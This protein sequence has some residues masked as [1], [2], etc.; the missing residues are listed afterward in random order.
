MNRHSL[1]VSLFLVV[2]LLFV[3]PVGGP[4]AAQ[5][6]GSSAQRTLQTLNDVNIPIRRA[7]EL[8]ERLGG[9]LGAAQAPAHLA[10]VYTPGDRH[11]FFVGD[12]DTDTTFEVEAELAAA[13]PG[14]YL[15]VEDGVDYDPVLLQQI[16]ELLD[17]RLFPALRELFGTE[18]SPGIDGDPHIY[19]LNAT[20]LGA[21]IGGYF[22]DNSVYS[23]TVIATSNEHEMFVIAVDNV[24]F[25]SSAYVYV[26]A[27]EFVHMIQHHEDENEQT[28]V[29]EGTAEL[30]AFLTVGPRLNAI[31]EFL[32]NPTL[33]LNSWDID[34]PR[35]YYGSSALFFSYLVERFG[36]EIVLAHSQEPTDG[37]VGIDNALE[38]IDATDPLTGAR[39][40]FNDVF[41][42]W[43]MANL[44][45][46]PQLQDGRYGYQT[47]DLNGSHAALTAV[48]D[49][50][51]ATLTDLP[52]N[53]FGANYLLLTSDTPTTLT[54]NFSGSTE[55]PVVPT[56][57]FSGTHVYWANRSDQSNPRL[58][59][60]FDLS[61]VSSATL[62]FATWYEME[63]FWD[64]SYLSVST[65]G[66]VKWTVLQTADATSE[67]P[68]G[69]AFAAG[70]TGYSG[71][72]TALR[73]APFIGVAYDNT[74][75]L[76]T[77]LVPEGG[78]AQAG[79]Q[80][81]DRLLAI[82][83]ILF[84]PREL[85]DHLNGYA[86]G[87]TITLTVER[88][89]AP[90][91]LPVLLGAHPDRKVRPTAQWIQELV[92]LT[93]YVGGEVLIRFEHVTDQAFT[94]NG[95]VLDDI[96]IP[97][98]GY[99]DDAESDGGGWENEGWARIENTLPQDYLVEALA[100]GGDTP[101]IRHLLSPGQGSSGS[102]Q[103]QVGPDAPAVLVLSGM[104]LH[105]T[106]PASYDLTIR[107][108]G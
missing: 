47:L 104:T 12:N 37:I 105:T 71:G 18:P 81:G 30:G 72:G 7:P 84:G 78:A 73:P 68:N 27:H 28:W 77:G 33:Q 90:L 83:N 57:A 6:G 41:A 55:V 65:D 5:G 23:Q 50:F 102:W 53:Q 35:P 19:I 56:Q 103:I 76:V 4:V 99:F 38:T 93:P 60:A 74:S 11:T 34:A 25:A 100:S 31:T 14:I 22:N 54:I 44:L 82:D 79:V 52:L 70:L 8:A 108:S 17:A 69:R 88:D 36:P 63:P 66:G 15:W 43:L 51:P 42:D 58:T 80:P 45:D 89:G 92:D 59:R 24:P 75:G 101:G 106:Q 1:S 2:V 85:L 46:N 20:H 10:P 26:L 13:T 16:A 87:D 96:R 64:Y 94:R 67:N 91:D 62:D 95:M 98:I 29:T 3:G 97:E 32:A 107:P 21:D 40:T 48:L 49:T 39:V 61:G 9:I 86:A